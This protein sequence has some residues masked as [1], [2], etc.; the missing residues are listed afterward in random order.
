MAKMQQKSGLYSRGVE[1]EKYESWLQA[2]YENIPLY[3]EALQ[4]TFKSNIK[5]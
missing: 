3:F 4:K 2:K 5:R 1:D